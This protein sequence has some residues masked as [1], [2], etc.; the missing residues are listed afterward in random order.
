MINQTVPLQNS[1]ILIVEDD[2]N[3]R[4][5]LTKL[6]QVEGVPLE[7]IVAL[8]GDPLAYLGVDSA[9]QF[10]LV[11]LD[12]QIPVKDGFTILAELRT[13][14]RFTAV[15]IVAVTANV[16]REDVEQARQAGFDGFLGKPINGP[17]LGERLKQILAGERVWATS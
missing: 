3:N 2:E 11:L 4:F 6:L 9:R 14:P 15:P 7:N 17:R 10:N 12:L 8:P 1:R 13:D 5:V 16:M